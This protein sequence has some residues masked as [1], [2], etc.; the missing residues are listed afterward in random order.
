M[1]SISGRLTSR[2]K[3]RISASLSPGTIK[4]KCWCCR[5]YW[6]LLLWT[7]CTFHVLCFHNTPRGRNKLVT[8]S[9]LIEAWVALAAQVLLL[10]TFLEMRGLLGITLK[11]PS[12]FSWLSS[13]PGLHTDAAFPNTQ[14]PR[15]NDS[16]SLLWGYECEQS[17]LKLAWKYRRIVST[18]VK[19]WQSLAKYET[20]LLLPS[21][22]LAPLSQTAV[23]HVFHFILS[24]EL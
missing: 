21:K 6:V 24:Q 20:A 16:S 8:C 18:F 7:T 4:D 23:E 10:N 5:L 17:G 15:A 14:T 19:E 1:V 2:A 13:D 11:T 3:A 12:D 22:T 9:F